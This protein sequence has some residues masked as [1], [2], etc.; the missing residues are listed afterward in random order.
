M[1]FEIKIVLC[2]YIVLIYSDVGSKLKWIGGG[3]VRFFRSF[4]K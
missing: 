3:G 4:D 2:F 1:Y